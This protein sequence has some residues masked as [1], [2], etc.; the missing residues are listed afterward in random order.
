V[1]A[2]VVVMVLVLVVVVVLVALALV[3]LAQHRLLG[4]TIELPIQSKRTTASLRI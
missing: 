2:V 1:T 4:L 3:R